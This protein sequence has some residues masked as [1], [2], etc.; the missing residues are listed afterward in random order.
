[1]GAVFGFVDII[2]S[3][4][5]DSLDS[6]G[7]EVRI[8]C[9]PEVGGRFGATLSTQ[10]V[11]ADVDDD[12]VV[13][14]P[15]VDSNDGEVYVLYNMGDLLECAEE[16]SLYVDFESRLHSAVQSPFGPNEEYGTVVATIGD[17]GELTGGVTTLPELAVIS[18]EGDLHIIPGLSM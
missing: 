10:N 5:G 15:G 6:T 17:F 13:G 8:L 9:Y 14:A 3:L 1:M 7:A 18:R 12:I 2:S 11:D 4:D 16:V